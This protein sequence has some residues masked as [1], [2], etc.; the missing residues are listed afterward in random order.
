MDV[1]PS[2]DDDDSTAATEWTS[3]EEQEQKA[4]LIQSHARGMIARKKFQNREKLA[5][6]CTR[7]RAGHGIMKE[8]TKRVGIEANIRALKKIL[9]SNNELWASC[10]GNL[11]GEKGTHITKFSR[12]GF[13]HV[14]VVTED[15]TIVFS[16]KPNRVDKFFDTQSMV[17]IPEK[18]S[19]IFEIKYD[20]D[21]HVDYD[22][23]LERV[24]LLHEDVLGPYLVKLMEHL[25]SINGS[26]KEISKWIAEPSDYLKFLTK[27]FDLEADLEI[28]D[29]ESLMKHLYNNVLKERTIGYDCQIRAKFDIELEAERVVL[30]KVLE[31]VSN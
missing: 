3:P 18:L 22:S 5:L 13:F 6:D 24:Q 27:T 2:K 20:E 19:G 14:Q 10:R 28:P 1:D 30:G 4:L 9:A 11:R 23:L 12:T 29:E 8:K 31:L 26:L 25:Q 7:S 21:L 15:D 16:T 17:S